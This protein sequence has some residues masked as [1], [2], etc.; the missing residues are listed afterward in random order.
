MNAKAENDRDKSRENEPNQDVDEDKSDENEEQQLKIFS[1]EIKSSKKKNKLTP[2]EKTK[3]QALREHER[4]IRTF[5]HQ[6]A[7]SF[8]MFYNE[9]R[10]K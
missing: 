1:K 5:K 6:Y 2:K 8:F 10:N 7:N 3:Q 4:E 9:Q